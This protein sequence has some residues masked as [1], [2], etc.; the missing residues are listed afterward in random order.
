MSVRCGALPLSFVVFSPFL[1]FSEH[2]CNRPR[3]YTHI[4]KEEEW[5]EEKKRSNSISL[6]Q[7]RLLL[8][9]SHCKTV[10]FYW[11]KHYCYILF[12][13]LNAEHLLF[14]IIQFFNSLR[15][16]IA[17][18]FWNI[19]LFFLQHFCLSKRNVQ[20][21]R[22]KYIYLQCAFSLRFCV[23]FPFFHS[24]MKKR[25]RLLF[26]DCF[27]NL[28]TWWLLCACSATEQI[29]VLFK[30][31]NVIFSANVSDSI[32]GVWIVLFSP[33]QYS[34]ISRVLLFFYSFSCI[35]YLYIF[36]FIIQNTQLW[37]PNIQR[38]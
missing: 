10:M 15:N 20:R 26:T 2:F 6:F 8:R 11:L 29:N 27:C 1:L 17:D 12:C 35:E 25:N 31:D 19:F 32:E 21:T 38:A 37:T 7:L 4:I 30:W 9:L 5:K 13:I 22:K 16:A 24:M 34:I 23:F 28:C 14:L 3:N 36:M 18:D 33:G